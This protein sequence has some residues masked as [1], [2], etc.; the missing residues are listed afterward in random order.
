MPLVQ[1]AEAIH[2]AA[3]QPHPAFSPQRFY[4]RVA[5]GVDRGVR[6][7]LRREIPV[8]DVRVPDAVTC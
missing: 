6:A 8:H 4:L 3:T 5:G 7:G 2:P 1:S